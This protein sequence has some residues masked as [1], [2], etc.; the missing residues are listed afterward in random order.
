MY[1]KF[2]LSV[3]LLFGLISISEADLVDYGNGLIYDT[4]QNIT[5]YD[6]TYRSQGWY[7]ALN[8]AANLEVTFNGINVSDWRLPKTNKGLT[9]NDYFNS[10]EMANLYFNELGNIGYPN[11]GWGLNNTSFFKNL[12]SYLYWS[13]DL[14]PN[15][16]QVWVFDFYYG[17]AGF[18]Y[19]Y[20]SEY[21]A[22]AVF[23]G[24]IREYTLNH[25][26]PV[27]EPSAIL[28]AFTSLLGGGAYIRRKFYSQI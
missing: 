9:Y 5:W 10:C 12:G 26:V 13:S 16:G 19:G 23:D 21:L 22:L 18:H 2:F 8:W 7:D 17:I 15:G 11:T 28:M 6:Y 14:D 4:D 1:A 20:Y 25:Q 24:D 3:A 27:P